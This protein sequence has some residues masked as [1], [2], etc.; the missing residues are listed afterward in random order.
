MNPIADETCPWKDLGLIPELVD[1]V[2][3]AGFERPTPIQAEAIPIA[4]QGRDVVGSARTGSGKTAA[5]VLP[6]IQRLV[7]SGGNPRPKQA[8]A[9]ILCPTRELAQ[10]IEDTI[11][12]LRGTLPIRS[13]T[14]VGGVSMTRQTT[15]L[16]D[17]VEFVVATPGR[18]LDLLRRRLISV[19]DVQALVLDE[20]D[21]MLDMG[22]LDQIDAIL[23]Q[24]PKQRQTMLFSATIDN[25]LDQLL[26]TNTQN[27]WRADVTS[28]IADIPKVEQRWIELMEID[29]R[30]TLLQLAAEEKGTMLV[31]VCT[32]SRANFCAG[33]LQ[34]EGYAALPM[35]AGL[36]QKERFA[37]LEAFRNGTARI[38][39]ATDLAARGLDV[40]AI[41]HVINYDMPH[42]PEDYIHRIGRTGRAGATGTATAFVTVG[43]RQTVRQVR[44]I[45]DQ[46]GPQPEI[47]ESPAK[48]FGRR[49]RRDD[50]ARR[51][52]TAGTSLL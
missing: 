45:L 40:E 17:G 44:R 38:L 49:M 12:M 42:A 6:I 23:A 14:V 24:M 22:F 20:A 10:Q 13:V 28:E 31:F 1:A 43:D 7:Q 4:L 21:R 3:K 25:A 36:D 9:T 46:Q 37:A 35:H 50:R 32:Q 52:P 26:R 16:K 5:F 51:G 18:L 30:R 11:R 33:A 15:A 39:V 19:V 27:P 41:S 47:P 2:H 8:L 48:Q 29:K 34:S